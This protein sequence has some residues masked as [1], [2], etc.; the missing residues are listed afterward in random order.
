MTVQPQVT[1]M[2]ATARRLTEQLVPVV[3]LRHGLKK[4]LLDASGTWL[5]FDDPE[6]AETAIRNQASLGRCP[7]LGVLLHPRGT[8]HVICADVDGIDA[9]VIS[10]LHACGVTHKDMTWT[11]TTGKGN[12][13]YHIFYS[14]NQDPLP[15]VSDKPDG[16]SIDLLANGYAVVAPSDTYLEPDGGGPYAWVNEHG[17]FDIPVSELAEPPD[18]LIAWWLSR[19]AGSTARSGSPRTSGGW[20]ANVL[21]SP[22]YKKTRNETLAKL[23]G[24][25]RTHYDT[26][27]T[28][29]LLQAINDARCSPPLPETEI[30]QIAASIGRMQNGKNTHFRAVRVAPM[31]EST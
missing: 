17:V 15:R 11:Q 21:D 7:N 31:G 3:L 1:A 2:V 16:I 4:P 6:D 24:S 8:S 19:K 25:L 18:A 12:G 29:A 26:G 9:N 5:T 23:A 22:I 13:H 27:T 20:L 10:T 28:A 30:A 14:R